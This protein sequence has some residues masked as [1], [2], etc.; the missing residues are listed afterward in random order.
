MMMHGKT[1]RAAALGLALL[2][3]TT[4]VLFAMVAWNRLAPP[5]SVLAL[6]ERELRPRAAADSERGRLLL[7]LVWRIP[8]TEE[9]DEDIALHRYGAGNHRSVPW[10]DRERVHA[11]GFTL[12]DEQE[13]WRRLP[14]QTR[15]VFVV[16]EFNGPA[17]RHTQQRLHALAHARLVETEGEPDTAAT[18]ARARRAQAYL[19]GEDAYSRVFLVDVGQSAHA[20][21][22]RYPDRGMHAIVRGRVSV[23]WVGEHGDEPR[24]YVRS[25]QTDRIYVPRAWR[26][27]LA[28]FERPEFGYG[29]AR[30]PPLRA[31]LAFGRRFEAWLREV[32]PP[33]KEE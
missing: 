5:D 21:R 8:W 11:L 18:G 2:L 6:S 12:P 23:T 32:T 33:P 28:G 7:E 30:P 19:D 17:Q 3:G 25:L 9:A 13:A 27:S 26:A 4:A 1:L 29:V 31:E 22:A 20:L 14:S 10:L 24:A 16:L 15:E